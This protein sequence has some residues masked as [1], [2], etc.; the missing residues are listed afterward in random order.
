MRRR[1]FITLVGGAAASTALS[2][3]ARAQQTL[4]VIGFLGSALPTTFPERMRAYFQ[5][6]REAG[7]EEGRNVAIEY[8]WAEGRIERLPA[9]ATELVHRKVDVIAAIGGPPQAL[10]VKAATSTIPVVFQ[11]GADPIALGLVASLSRPGGNLTGVA[12]LNVDV[13]PKRLEL[14]HELLPSA[15]TIAFLFNPANTSTAEM[16][17]KLFQTAAQTLGIELRALPAAAERDLEAAFARMIEAKVSGVVIANDVVFTSRSAQ[18]AELS[19]RDK[20]PAVSPFREFPMAGGLMS[21]GGDIL[22]AW[23]L[24]GVYTGRVLKGEKPADLPVQQSTK[25]E[26]IIN[27]KAARALGVTVP[28]LLLGRADE[29]IE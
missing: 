14:M 25:V 11:V 22:D 5:G 20:L 29:V 24:G 27:L 28:M 16:Q 2:P 10:A 19:L 26:L 9:L 8:R 21:Y 3:P 7:F 17:T 4:P 13:G 1:E 6:L 15:K 23:R 12:S 18:V